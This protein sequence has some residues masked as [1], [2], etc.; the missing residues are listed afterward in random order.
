MT[1]TGCTE[2][3]ENCEDV[4]IA[5]VYQDVKWKHIR[6]QQLHSQVRI[7][8]RYFIWDTSRVLSGGDMRRVTRSI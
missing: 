1:T 2:W 6:D 4:S 5:G 7:D 8:R 3:S